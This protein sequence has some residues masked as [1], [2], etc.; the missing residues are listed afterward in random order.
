MGYQICIHM[1][2]FLYIGWWVWYQYIRGKLIFQKQKIYLK[3]QPNTKVILII[4]IFNLFTNG[5]MFICEFLYFYIVLK[6]YLEAS[7]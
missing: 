3:N 5:E 1:P 7:I 2:T 6:R 4:I